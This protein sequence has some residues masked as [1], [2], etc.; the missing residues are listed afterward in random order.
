MNIEGNF[1]EISEENE[2]YAPGNWRWS[3]LYSS[4]EFGWI[5]SCFCVEG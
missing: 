3:L 4:R 1:D 2:E 5:M